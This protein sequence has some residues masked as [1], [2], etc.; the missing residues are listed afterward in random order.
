MA[1]DDL[2]G[3]K[4]QL[5]PPLARATDGVQPPTPA[6]AAGADADAS[7]RTGALAALEAAATCALA[8]PDEVL[9]DDRFDGRLVRA[10]E[11]PP[12]GHADGGG[13][14]RLRYPRAGAM[15]AVLCAAG[16]GERASRRAAGV[17]GRA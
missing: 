7:A 14:P 11:L 10:S 16:A 6:P 9:I 17:D 1:V 4:K 8:T 3:R 15:A 13:A 2:V 12:P 5:L